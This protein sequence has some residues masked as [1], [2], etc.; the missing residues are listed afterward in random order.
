MKYVWQ[1]HFLQPGGGRTGGHT[2]DTERARTLTT[3]QKFDETDRFFTAAIMIHVRV[4]LEDSFSDIHLK[5]GSEG[6]YLCLK[7]EKKLD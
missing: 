4:T 6:W 3:L 5:T 7:Q 2:G 1:Q